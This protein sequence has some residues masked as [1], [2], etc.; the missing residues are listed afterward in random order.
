MY[1][2]YTHFSL[3]YPLFFN[4]Y[5]SPC[6]GMYCPEFSICVDTSTDQ[7][8]FAECVCQF[9]RIKNPKTKQCVYPA[10][11]PPTKRPNPTLEVDIKNFIDKMLMII[12]LIDVVQ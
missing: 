9:G 11:P 5:C 10:S 1:D 3:I 6:E 4:V 12:M 7:D 8:A 2:E